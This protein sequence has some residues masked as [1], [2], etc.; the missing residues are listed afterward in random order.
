MKVIQSEGVWVP[1]PPPRIFLLVMTDGRRQYIHKTLASAAKQLRGPI[2]AKFIYDDSGDEANHGWLRTEFPDFHVIYQPT[3]QGF[4][5]AIYS[6]WNR[7]KQYDFDYIFHLEDDFLFNREIPLESM[8]KVLEY[9]PH[10][11]Q[12]AL[13]RQPW[14]SEEIRAGGFMEM[15]PSEF[16]QRDGWISHKL[17]FTS[18]PNIYRK[19]LIES[20]S[21]PNNIEG[22]E[23]QFSI[24]IL[25]SDPLA[26]FGFFGQKSDK[27]WVHHIGVQR[28]GGTY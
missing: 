13:K 19:S 4:G 16:Q 23:R 11:Y 14:N 17:F 18:N 24:E 21:Y 1:K 5:G 8:I 10:L 26:E 28:S 3:R 12:V 20:R 27:P 25:E 15:W 22:A 2:E 7:I 9:N 6:A